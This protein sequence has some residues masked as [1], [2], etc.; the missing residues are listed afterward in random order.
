MT[1]TYAGNSSG[2]PK[3]AGGCSS[4][5]GWRHCG[6]L[7]VIA[8]KW[9]EG[10]SR[11]GVEAAL[12]SVPAVF[13]RALGI[14]MSATVRM[15]VRSNAKRI[16]LPLLLVLFVISYSL[17]TT[18]VVRQSRTIN[19]QRTLIHLLFKDNVH[20]SASRGGKSP[21]GGQR[22]STAQG[23]VASSQAPASEPPSAQVPL[24]QVP[25]A[26]VPLIPFIQV[27]S[28]QVPSAELPSAQ[29]QVPSHARPQA[30]SKTDPKSR[31]AEK[32]LPMRPP[33]EV[34]D[35]S[36]MRRVRVSI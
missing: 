23:Q 20:L 4:G 6:S 5:E 35:P 21:Y 34:T 29:I 19:S 16:I 31:K 13:R 26:Q 3:C 28:V 17:L 15:E 30:N 10:A 8:M 9:L 18:L 32:Q 11:F 24:D 25:S 33:V 7:Q 27:P 2:Y 14:Q 22:T 1:A 12:V 36:D